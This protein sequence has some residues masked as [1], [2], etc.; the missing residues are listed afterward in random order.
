[1]PIVA[2]SLYN[3]FSSFLIDR[4]YTVNVPIKKELSGLKPG[5]GLGMGVED[6]TLVSRGKKVVGKGEIAE[7]RSFSN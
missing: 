6:K 5:E 3:Q 2:Y 1:M 4:I 7:D